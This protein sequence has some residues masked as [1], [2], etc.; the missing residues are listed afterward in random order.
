MS[1][2]TL[3]R[4]F[5]VQSLD[6]NFCQ[7]ERMRAWSGLGFFLMWRV[8][9]SSAR[10]CAWMSTNCASLWITSTSWYI[11]RLC[12]QIFEFRCLCHPSQSLFGWICRTCSTLP[13]AIGCWRSTV[14]VYNL[15]TASE[16]ETWGS[17][18]CQVR[19]CSQK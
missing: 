4:S 16:Q 17:E 18:L 13:V 5:D 8:S 15:G 2:T 14:S 10:N 3:S 11:G 12:M 6:L 9:L 19:V 7:A 1:L